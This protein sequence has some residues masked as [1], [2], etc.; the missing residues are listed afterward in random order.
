[1]AEE[2]IRQEFR[3]KNM[4]E[5]KNYFL[6]ETQQ[7]ELMNRKHKKVC[8]TLTYSKHFFILTSPVMDIFHF[9]LLLLCLVL[10]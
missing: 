2:N 5:K 7:N 4:D 1:M 6:K 9:L 10:L 8:T 3:F